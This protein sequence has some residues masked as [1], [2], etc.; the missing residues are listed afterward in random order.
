MANWTLESQSINFIIRNK[1][2]INHL[3]QRKLNYYYYRKISIH[4]LETK[5]RKSL[6]ISNYIQM[7]SRLHCIAA[8]LDLY[9]FH[10][11]GEELVNL[12]NFDIFSCSRTNSSR[13][14]EQSLFKFPK[15]TKSV[16]SIWISQNGYET[17]AWNFSF[18]ES[19]HMFSI[20]SLLQ[21]MSCTTAKSYNIT[22]KCLISP[23]K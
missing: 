10:Q 23:L 7:I 13:E 20:F 3:K 12:S 11:F 21:L 15:D 4:S 16:F 18:D 6:Q 8:A 2:P 1:S 9:G 19:T 17:S 5:K 22:V 14:R